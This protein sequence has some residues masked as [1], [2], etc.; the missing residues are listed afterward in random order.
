MIEEATYTTFRWGFAVTAALQ[1]LYL[2]NPVAGVIAGTAQV[3]IS[4]TLGFG[5]SLGLLQV[6][7]NL[8]TR[9]IQPHDLVGEGLNYMQMMQHEEARY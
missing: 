6:V 5:T 3:P 9:D 2:V 1:G 4:S 7:D 8:S